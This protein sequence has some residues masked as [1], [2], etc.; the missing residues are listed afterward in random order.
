MIPKLR[1]SRW[2]LLHNPCPAQFGGHYAGEMTRSH[3]RLH[4]VEFGSEV[5][6]IP[7]VR[8]RVQGEWIGRQVPR[9]K[10][11]TARVGAGARGGEERADSVA[12]HT[13][14]RARRGGPR[15]YK[16]VHGPNSDCGPNWVLSSLC[17]FFFSILNSFFKFKNLVFEF[18]CVVTFTPGLSGQIKV[19]S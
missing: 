16:L 6:A 15:G 1:S 19:P 7:C 9:R 18:K 4:D 14:V 11:C 5:V 10:S 2:R 13:S 12:P 17:F 8:D 3:L